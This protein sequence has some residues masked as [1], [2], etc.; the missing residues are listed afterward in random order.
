M[1]SE[2]LRI[3]PLPDVAHSRER[4]AIDDPQTLLSVGDILR[5]TR[6]YFL[7]IFLAVFVSLLLAVVYLYNATPIFTARAQLLIASNSQQFL[8]LLRENAVAGQLALD[9]A[10][11]EGEIALL[12]SETIAL[13]VIDKFNLTEEPEFQADELSAIGTVLNLAPTTGGQPH[14]D[15]EAASDEDASPDSPD[16]NSGNVFARFWSFL[17]TEVG[18]S[19]IAID[20]ASD[21]V[22]TRATLDI[23]LK[24]LDVR[25]VGYSYAIDISFSSTDPDRAAAIANEVAEAYVQ[26][27]LKTI[28]QSAQQSSKWLETQIIQNRDYLNAAARA[29]RKFRAGREGRPEDADKNPGPLQVPIGQDQPATL[30]ELESTVNTYQNIYESYLQALIEAVRRQS[31]PVSNARIITK[32]TRPSGKSYPRS[33]LVLSFVFLVGTLGGVGIAFIRMALDRSIRSPQQIQT[34]VGLN[35]IVQIP[36]MSR[37]AAKLPLSV[38]QREPF[39]P[40]SGALRTLQNAIEYADKKQAAL[41]VGV[42]SAVAGEGT[43]AVAANLGAL[44]E[45]ATGKTLI[46]D[47][48][49][50]GSTISKTFAPNSENGLIEVLRDN[51]A[52]QDCIISSGV[53]GPDLL[54]VVASGDRVASYGLIGSAKI[55]KLIDELRDQYRIIIV[56]L[57]P[58]YPIAD[59][60]ALSSRLDGVILAVEWGKTTIDLLT[61]VTRALDTAGTN[62]LGAVITKV[63]VATS[64]F[65]IGKNRF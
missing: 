7:T 53:A 45:I 39:S 36:R 12:R 57:P 23:F 58:L 17:A 22:K 59:A 42:T 43:S 54:P 38:V 33:K 27:Q 64:T 63:P 4:R 18:Q 31:F 47:A 28:V 3:A 13:A 56:D 62:I 9:T 14:K 46:I 44:F 52:A 65:S 16:E 10:Q 19:G 41:I 34:Q 48:D 8:Q 1:G 24:K 15:G 11:V 26:D 20:N 32:A 2:M 55:V 51:V 29:F 6:R 21:Y 60:L 37:K 49:I 50:H 25:R 35:C 5:F 40:F 61:D 30:E